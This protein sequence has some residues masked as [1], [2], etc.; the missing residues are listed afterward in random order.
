MAHGDEVTGQGTRGGRLVQACKSTGACKSAVVQQCS[1]V[2]H[3]RGRARRHRVS[4]R[5]LGSRGRY[6]VHSA[7]GHNRSDIARAKRDRVLYV[8]FRTVLGRS[9]TP[10]AR[11]WVWGGG[12]GITLQVQQRDRVL[13]NA[14]HIPVPGCR[15]VLARRLARKG[16]AS[17]LCLTLGL[18]ESRVEQEFSWRASYRTLLL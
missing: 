14:V 17:D 5:R 6:L 18:T 13:P 2:Q 4:Y 1:A 3:V 15:R 16:A 7:K 10:I 12:A 11:V 9:R 8:L